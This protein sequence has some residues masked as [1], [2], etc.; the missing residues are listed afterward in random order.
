MA[1]CRQLADH[2]RR[3]YIENPAVRDTFEDSIV[4][5]ITD[6]CLALDTFA[7]ADESYQADTISDQELTYDYID[8]LMVVLRDERKVCLPE[9]MQKPLSMVEIVLSDM[10]KRIL[11]FAYLQID[12]IR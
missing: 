5:Y 3:R 7:D 9:S 6:I 8:P 1:R 11:S 4:D 12:P 2:F 10:Y